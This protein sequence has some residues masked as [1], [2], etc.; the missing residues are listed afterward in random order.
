LLDEDELF[1]NDSEEGLCLLKLV[2]I[3]V[4]LLIAVSSFELLILGDD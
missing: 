1:I 2:D 4:L 3:F